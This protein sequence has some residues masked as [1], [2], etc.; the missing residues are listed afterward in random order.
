MNALRLYW[1]CVGAS[2]RAQMQY[3][4][5]FLFLCLAHFLFA[6]GEFL[7]IWSLFHRFGRLR[8]W[9]LAE[10]ALLYGMVN[11]SYAIA[12]SL[13]AGL[14]SVGAMVKSGE[15]DRLLL[16]P[17][18]LL[19]QLLARE[20]RVRVL[21]GRAAQSVLVLTWAVASLPEA[22]SAQEALLFLAAVGGGACLF[23][24]IR[25]LHA[26]WSFWTIESL[27]IM[28]LLAVGGMEAGQYPLSIYRPWL[29]QFLTYVVPMAA[30]AYFPALILLGRSDP[31][32]VA[33][34]VGWISPAAGVLF[35]ALAT[36]VWK[37]GVRHYQS[38]GS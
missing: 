15:F 23:L 21:L 32:G 25:L 38:T 3:R 20:L 13:C 7:A 30:V 9:D 29:Q 10:V 28:Q 8:S 1:S 33:S 5:S 11:L 31:S 19:L 36:R 18:G 6:C 12:D 35:L 17:R 22:W 37:F 24:G 2:A 4:V 34:W 26:T 14:E 16:R 27:E